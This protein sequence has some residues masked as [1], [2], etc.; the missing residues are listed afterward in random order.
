MLEIRTLTGTRLDIYPNATIEVNMGG[1]SLLNLQDRTATYTNSFSLPRT[2]TN[3]VVFAFASQPTRNNRPSIDVVVTKG[4]FQR[5]AVL[6]AI[7]FDNE[8]KCSV[9]YSDGLEKLTRSVEGL[10]RSNVDVQYG[11][12]NL[13][14]IANKLMSSGAGLNA[15][16]LYMPETTGKIATSFNGFTQVVKG[17]TLSIRI[18][19]LFQYIEGL[20]FDI[21]GDILSDADFDL[22]YWILSNMEIRRNGFTPPYSY[23]IIEKSNSKTTPLSD[24]LKKIALLFNCDVIFKGN[25]IK[26]NKLNTNRTPVIIE[27]LKFQKKEIEN[28]LGINNYV[29]YSINKEI[30]DTTGLI[31]NITSDGIGDKTICDIGLYAPSYINF[32]LNGEDDEFLSKS[33]ALKRTASALFNRDVSFFGSI[34]NNLTFDFNTLSITNFYKTVLQPLFTNILT[35]EANGYIDPIT[36]DTIMN[37]RVITSVQLGGRYWV[38]Q[39]AYNLTTGQSK[40]TLIKLP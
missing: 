9:R 13:S 8:Y 26:I 11:A 2:P 7:E 22:C 10:V 31:E 27:N 3:E 16:I 17:N 32:I 39:F 23:S 36:A 34:Y 12:S 25:E 28:K 29:T 20:G 1:I 21:T 4:L 14:D 38:D 5:Q 37:N 18:K 6:K 33:I 15:D 19:Y 40:L 35:Q 30:V 24:V